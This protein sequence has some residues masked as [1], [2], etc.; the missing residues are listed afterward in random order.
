MLSC[1]EEQY[2]NPLLRRCISCNLNCDHESLSTCVA[3][4]KSLRC[5]KEPGKYYY[6]HLLRKC[7][8]CVST[9]GQHPKQ[10]TYFCENK[11]RSHTNLSPELRRQQT[12]EVD[13]KSGNAGRYQGSEHSVPEA[14][15]EPLGPK[16]SAEPLALVYSTLGLCLCAVLCC[17]L[18]AVVACVLRRKGE[19]LSSQR[20]MGPRKPTPKSTHDPVMEAG[21]APG[22][23][24]MLGPVEPVETCSLCFP[25]RRAPTQESA[26]APGTPGLEDSSLLASGCRTAGVGTAAAP[27]AHA[28]DDGHPAQD[29]RRGA[30]W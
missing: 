19:P 6:D 28:P 3:F 7:V 22:A 11:L 5:R 15:A 10:C 1:P 13:R 29:A 30:R 12:G 17:C 23:M 20:P 4:C 18:V 24:P 9:C 25:E 16:G 2:W 14:G 21:G 26:G 8:S 27:C